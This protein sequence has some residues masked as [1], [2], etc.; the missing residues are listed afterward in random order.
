MT[1]LSEKRYPVCG[2]A[3]EESAFTWVVRDATVAYQCAAI[4]AD[5]GGTIRAATICPTPSLVQAELM[6]AKANARGTL[7]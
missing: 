7:A 6:S 1:L 3:D 2:A 5:I 4:F